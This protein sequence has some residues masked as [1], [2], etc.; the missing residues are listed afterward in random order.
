MAIKLAGNFSVRV[1]AAAVLYGALTACPRR[2]AKQT[3]VDNTKPTV[4]APVAKPAAKK[5]SHAPGT[6]AQPAAALRVTLEWLAGSRDMPAMLYVRLL[7][8]L[9]P[10]HHRFSPPATN[11]P[12]L[13]LAAPPDWTAALELRRQDQPDAPAKPWSSGWK[14]VAAPKATQLQIQPGS[15]HQLSCVVEAAAAPPPGA[16]VTAT[17]KLDGLTVESA[18]L[19]VPSPPENEREAKLAGVTATLAAGDAVAALAVADRWIAAEPARHEGYWCRGQAL[20]ARG[21][22][23]GALA[24]YRAAL[25]RYP[26]LADMGSGWEPPDRLWQKVETLEK[27]APR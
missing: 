18:P 12:A 14:I 11:P 7:P 1:L 15:F 5:M 26:K 21:D 23:A 2:P 13:S 4:A 10:P 22:V 25:E 16:L 9:P 17:V 6:P 24:A 19:T 20:E 3:A 8:V 27:S